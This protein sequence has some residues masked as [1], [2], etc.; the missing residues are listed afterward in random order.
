MAFCGKENGDYAAFLKKCNIFPCCLSISNEFLGIF[1][2][3]VFIYVNVGCLKVKECMM[4]YICSAICLHGAEISLALGE[5]YV[6]SFYSIH[7]KIPSVAYIIHSM[8]R[9]KFNL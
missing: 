2:I 6:S 5:L 9:G 8:K 1:F 7:G 3:H 4:L